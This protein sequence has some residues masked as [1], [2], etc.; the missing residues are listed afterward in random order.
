M[1]KKNGVK[2]KLSLIK[3]EK[4]QENKVLKLNNNKAKKIKLAAIL[5][6]KKAIIQTIDWHRN[7]KRY[8]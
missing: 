3:K 4:F 6:F 1:S 2:L 7:K 8:S 5:H